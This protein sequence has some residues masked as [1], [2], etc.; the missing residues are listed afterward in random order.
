MF[1]TILTL[2]LILFTL[3]VWGKEVDVFNTIDSLEWSGDSK[4]STPESP[5]WS[6]TL[7]W[8]LAGTEVEI[9][10]SFSLRMPC[11]FK[12][13]TDSPIVWLGVGGVNYAVCNLISGEIMQTSSE[14]LCFVTGLLQPNQVITG[15]LTVSFVFNSGHSTLD[16]DLECSNAYNAGDNTITFQAGTK[17][18]ST[19]VNFATL[20]RNEDFMEVKLVPSLNQLQV[21]IGVPPCL[22]GYTGFEVALDTEFSFVPGDSYIGVADK[23]NPWGYPQSSV[24]GS[25]EI[26]PSGNTVALKLNDESA[27]SG[28]GFATFMLVNEEASYSVKYIY[29]FYCGNS[30]FSGMV[31]NNIV[32]YA[33]NSAIVAASEPIQVTTQTLANIV[34]TQVSTVSG[35]SNDITIIVNVPAPTSTITS[36]WE[37]QESSTTTQPW[38]GGTVT[39]IEL[40]PTPTTTLT[41]WWLSDSTSSSTELG[42]EVTIWIFE[43]AQRISSNTTWDR[44]TTSTLTLWDEGNG[45]ATIYVLTPE[46]NESSSSNVSSDDA[47]TEMETSNSVQMSENTESSNDEIA[48]S[49][50]GPSESEQQEPEETE[51]DMDFDEDF[52]L[53]EVIETN[54]ESQTSTPQPNVSS[55][56]VNVSDPEELSVQQDE[57]ISSQVTRSPS[58]VM[59]TDN[60]SYPSLTRTFTTVAG[61]ANTPVFMEASSTQETKSEDDAPIES[62]INTSLVTD[63]PLI[64]SDNT[65]NEEI[66]MAG[67]LLIEQSNLVEAGTIGS[68]ESNNNE[69]N[70]VGVDSINVGDGEANSNV[71]TNSDAVYLTVASDP[72]VQ[73]GD[74]NGNANFDVIGGEDVG[75]DTAQDVQQQDVPVVDGA[76]VGGAVVDE[77]VAMGDA[78]ISEALP[79]ND[80]LM[81]YDGSGSGLQTS[82]WLAIVAI[83]IL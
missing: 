3:D 60:E 49:T 22:D 47:S 30:G 38:N 61:L 10:D 14:M 73:D 55:S 11:V 18:L 56:V 50:Q 74:V 25:Y 48:I 81:E 69:N 46:S 19:Q 17:Q 33:D 23:I 37:L 45:T 9:G 64:S 53:E 72:H 13:T 66:N 65:V 35:N 31:T 58:N 62:K 44:D 7:G 29:Q 34:T 16:T 52:G 32:G 70:N 41:T 1:K 12:F 76:V 75:F 15:I 78:T 54:E 6:V 5:S 71:S 68:H 21:Y 57:L 59:A 8:E 39:V 79:A 77:I 42:S 20:Q 80:I 43:P 4:D 28:F 27:P 2:S 67:D 40:V 24:G 82:W 26:T 51:T 36:T 63:V 83:L